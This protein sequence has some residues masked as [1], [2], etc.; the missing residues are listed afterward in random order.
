M[1]K[2]YRCGEPDETVRVRRF[3][4]SMTVSSCDPCSE[5]KDLSRYFGQDP[6]AGDP[7]QDK[8]SHYFFR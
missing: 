6:N 3:D 1:D 4:A 2:C 5:V 8:D 7:T